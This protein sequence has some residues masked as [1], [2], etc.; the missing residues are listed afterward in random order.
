M[1]H[2]VNLGRDPKPDEKSGTSPTNAQVRKSSLPQ[3]HVPR[4]SIYGLIGHKGPDPGV[5]GGANTGGKSADD[6]DEIDQI[7]DYVRGFAPL[8]KSAKGWQYIAETAHDDKKEPI[9]QKLAS[10]ADSENKPPEPPPIDTIP[11]RKPT[12][13]MSPMDVTPPMTPPFSPPWAAGHQTQ[14]PVMTPLGQ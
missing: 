2:D 9:Y 13:G 8:P 6:Y 14:S 3:N 4:N 5:G 12:A 11:T 10:H 1:V 7:Y